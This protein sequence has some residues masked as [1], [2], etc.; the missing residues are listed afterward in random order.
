M[1]ERTCV[2]RSDEN[3]CPLKRITPLDLYTHELLVKQTKSCP[4]VKWRRKSERHSSWHRSQTMDVVVRLIVN[5]RPPGNPPVSS[6]FPNS[7][8]AGEYNILSE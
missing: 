6:T 4:K 8:I 1:V 2:V 3:R 7:T 5:R